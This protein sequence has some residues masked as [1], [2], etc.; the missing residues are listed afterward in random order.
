MYT[1][2]GFGPRNPPQKVIG[3]IAEDMVSI[4]CKSEIE[5]ENLLEMREWKWIEERI[6]QVKGW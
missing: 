2:P 1:F 4:S 6:F 3:L 5:V